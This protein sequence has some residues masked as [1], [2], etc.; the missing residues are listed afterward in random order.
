MP[1]GYPIHPTI[2]KTLDEKRKVLSRTK[3][4]DPYSPRKP[5]TKKEY[6]KNIIRTPYVFMVSAPTYDEDEV[7]R[8]EMPTGTIILGNQEYSSLPHGG[9]TNFW[10]QGWSRQYRTISDKNENAPW[11]D[12]NGVCFFTGIYKVGSYF[13]LLIYLSPFF[14]PRASM[15]SLYFCTL[16]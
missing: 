4:P 10:G 7:K 8:G 14:I 9:R 2:R 12:L 6:Q 1:L 16:V 15:K 11:I 3:T 5:E 13:N